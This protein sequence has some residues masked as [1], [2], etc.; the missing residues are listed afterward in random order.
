MM[1]DIGWL[2]PVHTTAVLFRR[3]PGSPAIVATSGN[4]TIRRMAK[5]RSPPTAAEPPRILVIE[6]ELLIALFIEEMIREIG[7]RV[8]GVAYTDALARH[9]LAKRNFDAV[10]CDIN[11]GGQYHLEIADR[12]IELDIPFAFVTGYDYL[13][14]PRHEKLPDPTNRS[15]PSSCAICCSRSSDRVPTGRNCPAGLNRLGPAEL[16]PHKIS[17]L[18]LNEPQLPLK[19]WEPI[20]MSAIGT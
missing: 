6:D 12:L 15:R 9:E 20:R 17:R 18:D 13:V 7:Y 1:G 11:I 4:W 8:S 16:L 3:E 14:E 2:G 19:M 5:L 10:L